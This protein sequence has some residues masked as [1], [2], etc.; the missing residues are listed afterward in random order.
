M[1]RRDDFTDMSSSRPYLIRAIYQWISDN[2]LTP[3]IL[4]DAEAPG[5]QVP[6]R[7]VENG[8]IILNISGRAVEG[9]H[10]DNQW[11]SFQARFGGRSMEV[12]V[13]VEA[14]LAIYA[15][16]NGRGMVLE[17][18]DGPPPPERPTPPERPRRPR[19]QVVK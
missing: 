16:E 4:V 5:V 3:Y 15:Q 1:D 10:I 8:K 19:L 12:M 17:A 18:G 6:S 9:L 7:Y 11:I 14:V 2:G 13:P